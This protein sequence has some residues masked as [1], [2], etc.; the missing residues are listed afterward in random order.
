MS[1]LDK[2]RA[3]VL[4]VEEMGMQGEGE[5][6]L[7]MGA[8]GAGK[9]SLICYL[10]G[11]E[12]QW[13]KAK[14]K[15]HLH[16]KSTGQFPGI[17]NGGRSTDS[18]PMAFGKYIDSAGF[19]EETELEK[20]VK[21]SCI[22]A[23]LLG[24]GSRVKVVVMLEFASLAT[25]RGK[26]IADVANRLLDLFP[27][28]W[29][30]MMDSVVVVVSK[31]N[32]AEVEL[33]EVI[34][35]IS[36]IVSSNDNIST[37]AKAVM[38]RALESNRVALF[39]LP[40]GISTEAIGDISSKIDSVAECTLGQDANISLGEGAKWKLNKLVEGVEEAAGDHVREMRRFLE[41]KY[42]Q[43]LEERAMEEVLGELRLAKQILE[44]E[45]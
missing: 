36:S 41:S 12:L 33:E 13:E 31:V 5:T 4:K 19:M 22:L 15:H 45:G 40:N 37:G 21:T 20:E 44:A 18:L 42:K 10:M 17:A 23:K 34:S 39:P 35:E 2:I 32:A 38:M 16:N 1:Q 30:G 25:V 3:E 29:E 27:G 26:S 43:K 9:S 14:L 28:D 6:V 24:K 8:G 7:V 11:A